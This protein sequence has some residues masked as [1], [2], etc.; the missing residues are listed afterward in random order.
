MRTC[1]KLAAL[2]RTR[3]SAL[4]RGCGRD[5]RVLLQLATAAAVSTGVRV[6]HAVDVVPVCKVGVGVRFRVRVSDR[7]MVRARIRVELGL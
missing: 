6:Q 3:G 7:A 5:G 1:K 4:A 2:P